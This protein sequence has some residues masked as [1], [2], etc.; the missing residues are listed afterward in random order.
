MAQ[1]FRLYIGTVLTY[2]QVGVNV[3]GLPDFHIHT[4]IISKSIKETELYKYQ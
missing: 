4:T 1:K 3:I 2:F